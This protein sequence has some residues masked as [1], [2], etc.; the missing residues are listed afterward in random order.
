[1]LPVI[2]TG[3]LED[4]QLLDCYAMNLSVS[5][6]PFIGFDAKTFYF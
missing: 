5:L 6:C 4:W 2:L 3:P 1:M